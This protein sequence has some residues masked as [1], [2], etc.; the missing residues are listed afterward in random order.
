MIRIIAGIIGTQCIFF[1]ILILCHKIAGPKN[2]ASQYAYTSLTL[3]SLFR[4]RRLRAS[5]RL[6]I[7]KGSQA[8]GERSLPWVIIG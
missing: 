6:A 2:A 7:G 5:R 1:M 3:G 4:F 8:Q